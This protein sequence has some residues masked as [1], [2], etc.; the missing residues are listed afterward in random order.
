VRSVKDRHDL[1]L[2]WNRCH[3]LP[4]WVCL[5]LPTLGEGL[6]RH[7]IFHHGAVL[8]LVFNWVRVVWTDRFEK[9]LDMVLQLPC[10]M[11][12]IMFDG[13]DIL[14]T[15]VVSFLIVAIIVCRNSVALVLP[16][17]TALSA[18]PSTLDGGLG[19]C[20]ST[21]AGSC[22]HIAQNEGGPNRV[23]ARGVSSTNVK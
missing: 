6:E 5:G 9:F 23:L 21:A 18:F 15:G 11:L 8:E 16:L 4:A 10:F 12:E 1:H 13:R 2:P 19:S 3:A 22:Y 14:L 20:F 17:P 7:Q